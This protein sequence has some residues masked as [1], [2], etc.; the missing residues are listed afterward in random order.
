MWQQSPTTPGVPAGTSGSRSERDKVSDRLDG[1]LVGDSDKTLGSLLEVFEKKGFAIAFVLLLG[2]SALPLPTGGATH[3][4]EIIAACSPRADRRQRTHLAT[5]AWAQARTGGPQT[6]ALPHR[7]DE[8]DRQLER[9]SRPRLPVRPSSEQHRLRAARDRRI[10]GR[11]LRPAVHRTRHP[12]LARRRAAVAR[13]AAG[14]LPRLSPCAASRALVPPV[15]V[16]V[17]A[18]LP[19]LAQ[20]RGAEVPVGANLTGDSPQVA[21]EVYDRGAPPEPVAVVDAVD[22]EPGLEHERVRDHRVVIG[23]G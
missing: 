16:R 8:E 1:W 6:S 2:V 5:A 22:D 12:A 20:P 21:P 18:R 7:A 15:E 17:V 23:V 19:G 4:F 14:G 10:R 9:F 11:L 13:R 3:V